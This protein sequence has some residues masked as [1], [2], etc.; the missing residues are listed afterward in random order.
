MADRFLPS[1]SLG[2]PFRP[3]LEGIF[4]PEIPVFQPS[5]M[6]GNTP[7]SDIGMTGRMQGQFGGNINSPEMPMQRSRIESS[8]SPETRY[9]DMYEQILGSMPQREDPSIWRRLGA[10]F[11]GN[12]QEQEAFKYAPF[13]RK[14]QDWENRREAIE[15]GL[16]AERYSNANER[17]VRSSEMQNEAANR[18][19]TVQ[20]EDLKRKE[21]EGEVK[22]EQRNEEIKIRKQRADTY[23][24]RTENPNKIIK[25]DDKGNLIGVDPQSGEV[26]YL[27]DSDGDPIK[28]INLTPEQRHNNRMKEIAAQGANALSRT[29]VA[30]EEARKTEGVRSANDA[31]EIAAR[32]EQARTTKATPSVKAIDDPNSV[33]TTTSS[34]TVK[35]AKGVPQGTRTT[36]TQRSTQKGSNVGVKMKFP[37]GTTRLVPKDRQKEME[38]VGGK[39]VP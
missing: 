22:A 30:G 14:M 24:Y 12:P 21:R 33:Q 35:D 7:E 37:D 27:L 3:R 8:Y 20:E 34:V 10:I 1:E 17:Q 11:A 29:R 23:Q 19:I 32:G 25:E 13:N 36:T 6:M 39:V 16:T 26:E 4:G 38:K 5:Q 2:S 31:K 9:Q 18:R 15:P 28:S